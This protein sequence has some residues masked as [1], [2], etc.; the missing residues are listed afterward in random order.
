M[1]Y[2]IW[3][4][5]RIFLWMIKKHLRAGTEAWRQGLGTLKEAS[6]SQLGSRTSLLISGLLA[7]ELC[8]AGSTSPLGTIVT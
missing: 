8:T 1:L 4:P 3:R 2:W 5:R 6:S 7:A